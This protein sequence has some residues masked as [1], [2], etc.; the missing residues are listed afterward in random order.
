ML[1][2][3]TNEENCTTLEGQDLDL[4]FI[5]FVSPLGPLPSQKHYLDYV[6]E[7]G[8]KGL[9]RNPKIQFKSPIY[10]E[11]TRV[12]NKR[13]ITFFDSERYPIAQGEGAQPCT[14]AS[15]EVM[16]N[17]FTDPTGDFSLNTFVDL[18]NV[19][20]LW[21][22]PQNTYEYPLGLSWEYPMWGGIVYD[23][24]LS[25]NIISVIPY[26]R[27]FKN[28]SSLGDPKWTRSEWSLGEN[29]EHCFKYCDNPSFDTS[30]QYQ[31]NS[32]WRTKGKYC[33]DISYPIPSEIMP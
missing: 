29:I 6:E 8:D 27:S 5:N 23:S 15:D 20:P 26:T 31:V 7:Y 1:E 18:Y 17:V 30:G 14:R 19:S 3:G 10:N 24:A 28:Y 11:N 16:S 25:G 33:E 21:L 32:S 22:D 2:I 12:F 4:R 13:Q 9:A